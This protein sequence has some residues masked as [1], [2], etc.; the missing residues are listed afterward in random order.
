[1]NFVLV[2]DLSH[3][4]ALSLV[5]HERSIEKCETSTAVAV[6]LLARPPAESVGGKA[7]ALLCAAAASMSAL[8]AP[9]DAAM[10]P[11]A[12]PMGKY[13]C[14]FGFALLPLLRL[15]LLRT[16]LFQTCPKFYGLHFPTGSGG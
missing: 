13:F 15:Y 16:C 3:S 8:A 4:H 2:T 14:A 7:Q 11:P 6:C 10:R 9:S 1:M 12:Q 5:V